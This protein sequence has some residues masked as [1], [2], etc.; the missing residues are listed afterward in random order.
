M[1]KI[2]LILIC[3]LLLI[4][5]NSILPFFAI[6]GVFG[7]I[8]FVFSLAISINSNK[9]DAI[10]VGVVSGLLQDIFFAN[11]IGIN[12][13]INMF[14]CLGCSI[15]GESIFKNKSIIPVAISF[16]AT[17][18]KYISVYLIGNF[19]NIDINM[20]GIKVMCLYNAFI[21]FVIYKQVYKFANKD[22]MKEP[23][24]F[25]K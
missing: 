9:W 2:I 12:P 20:S 13:L 8:L 16:G 17:L 25:Y 3:I 7:S 10:T 11:V 22:I 21:M 15:L 18:I 24:S 1:K 6:K 14:L 23:W 5:D 19:I 4:V